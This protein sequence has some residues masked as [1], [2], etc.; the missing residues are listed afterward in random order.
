MIKMER[1]GI[2]ESGEVL[3]SYGALSYHDPVAPAL[4]I[5]APR[6]CLAGWIDVDGGDDA[7]LLSL[8]EEPSS[9]RIRSLPGR[10]TQCPA[11][12]LI[13]KWFGPGGSLSPAEAQSAA[14]LEGDTLEQLATVGIPVPRVLAVAT[15]LGS[16]AL[17]MEEIPGRRTLAEVLASASPSEQCSYGQELGQLVGRLH[18]AGWT[19]RDLYLEHF[20]VRSGD[21]TGRLVLIDLGRA[22]Q[23]HEALP[24]VIGRRQIKDLSALM[25]SAPPT[26][27]IRARVA[28]WRAWCA[29][30]G[31]TDR[32]TSRRVLRSIAGHRTR[33]A[34]HVPLHG[35][36]APRPGHLLLRLPN[37]VG[38]LVMATPILQE[39]CR[40]P[41][42][43]RVTALVKPGLAPLLEGGLFEGLEVIARKNAAEERRLM[44]TLAPDAV[45]LLNHSLGSAIAARRAGI[46]AIIGLAVGGRGPLLTHAL[47][48]PSRGGRR[49]PVP[50]AH[51][52]RDVAGLAGLVVQDLHPRLGISP[53]AV[54]RVAE[55]LEELGIASHQTL[56]LCSPG[57]AKGAGKLWPTSRFAQTLDGLVEGSNR[58]ALVVGGPGEE[59]LVAEVVA[60]AGPGVSALPRLQG[61]DGLCALVERAQ[62]LL[63]GDSGPRWIAAAFDTPCVCV[64]GPNFPE[65]TA[66]SLEFCSVLRLEGLEC[67]PCLERTCPLGHQRCM[68]ELPVAPVLKAARAWLDQPAGVLR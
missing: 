61:L 13:H 3:R 39:A 10:I 60:Q 55:V 30:V 58:H 9:S 51:L 4:R 48:P 12:G 59:D 15:G 19:H 46:P 20:L 26:L 45:L 35:E 2:L 1:Q 29:Q 25:H 34:R 41:R 21:S 44:K 16:S 24:L 8:L 49:L 50:T 32:A 52:Q 22:R 17:V 28:F 27:S 53:E 31:N 40:S 56:I 23:G 36:G 18:A 37:W 11:P 64:M 65:L 57:A 62:L 7:V 54:Q 43:S 33:M 6:S 63:V 67:A 42:W 14:Q 66:T 38:D 5:I 47:V 68:T